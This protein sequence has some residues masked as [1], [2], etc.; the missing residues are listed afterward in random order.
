MKYAVYSSIALLLSFAAGYMIVRFFNRKRNIS[1]LKRVLLTILSG[2]L[3]I[4][5]IS[6]AY[7]LPYQKAEPVC[8]EY[9]TSSDN[10]QFIEDSSFYAFLHSDSDTVFIIYPGAKVDHHAYG[11]LASHLAASGMDVYVIRMPFHMALF[12]IRAADAIL[13]NDSYSRAYLCGHSLGGTMAARYVIDNPD[14]ASGLILLAS[15]P[16]KKLPDDV[17]ML[18]IYGD[19]DG[20]LEMEPYR[21][22]RDNWP[23]VSLEQVIEGGNHAQFG[24]YGFQKGD[25]TASITADQQISETAEVIISFLK[26]SH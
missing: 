4:S 2:T 14:K 16:D 20:C 26:Q 17:L 22:A 25:G 12:N 21:N 15:Y 13:K 23:K 6:L 7:L 5:L 10:Y 11:Q 9:L 24:Q 8:N 1:N 3:I 18:S 19:H